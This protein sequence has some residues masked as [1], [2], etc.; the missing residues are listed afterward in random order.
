MIRTP[1]QN[2]SIAYGLLST[3]AIMAKDVTNK[4][5]A[6]TGTRIWSQPHEFFVTN[7]VII[8]GYQ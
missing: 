2:I 8:V 7:A 3:L 4:P 6:E 5:N 1:L